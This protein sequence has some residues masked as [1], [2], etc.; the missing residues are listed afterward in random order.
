MSCVFRITIARIQHP[1][2]RRYFT[3]ET[4]CGGRAYWHRPISARL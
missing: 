3:I 4:S 2:L 1:I